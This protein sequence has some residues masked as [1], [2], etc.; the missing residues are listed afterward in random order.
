MKSE[1]LILI[2]FL[3]INCISQNSEEFYDSNWTQEILR[4]D[5]GDF[6][7][8]Y[9]IE[10][11]VDNFNN[12]DIIIK[13]QHN[14]LSIYQ[15]TSPTNFIV[16]NKSE[17]PYTL[18]IKSGYDNYTVQSSIIGRN[19]GFLAFGKSSTLYKLITK[20]KGRWLKIVIYNNRD[21]R[22][23]SFSLDTFEPIFE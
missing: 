18:K 15:G 8:Y 14:G 23:N 20:G 11:S 12:N 21:E 9:Y 3:S 17:T 22:I 7:N 1:I 10:T 4:D 6:K 2:L 5:F 13:L 19:K 16:Y